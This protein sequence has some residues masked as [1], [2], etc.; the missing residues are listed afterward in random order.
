MF[1]FSRAEQGI[2]EEKRKVIRMRYNKIAT[3]E[4]WEFVTVPVA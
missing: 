2:K 4:F 3:R 1:P